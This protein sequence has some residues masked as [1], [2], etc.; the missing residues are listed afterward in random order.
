MVTEINGWHP[1]RGGSDHVGRLQKMDQH[2]PPHFLPDWVEVYI[3][4]EYL[5][6]K[7]S[8]L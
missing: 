8:G 7:Y 1:G 3:R 2:N 5:H 6:C 4:E